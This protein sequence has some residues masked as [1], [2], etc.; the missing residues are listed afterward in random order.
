MSAEPAQHAELVRIFHGH[1]ASEH[2][3]HEMVTLG[4]LD[5]RDRLGRSHKHGS[6]LWVEELCNN[7][8]C[9]ARAIVSSEAITSMVER[10]IDGQVGPS[11][12][13]A[14]THNDA[15]EA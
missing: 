6:H 9:T 5:Y 3:Y 2:D 10:L 7:P 12:S 15:G 1:D 4:R 14:A 13:E 8:D 11:S